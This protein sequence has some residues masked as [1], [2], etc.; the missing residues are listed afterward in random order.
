MRGR[1][2]RRGR[3]DRRRGRR[4]ARPGLRVLRR[5]SRAGARAG[6]RLHQSTAVDARRAQTPRVAPA[7]RALFVRADSEGMGATRQSG[8]SP[9]PMRAGRRSTISYSARCSSAGAAPRSRRPSASADASWKSASAPA[10]RCRIIRAPTDSSASTFPSRCCARRR[11]GCASCKLDNVETLAGDGRQP[12]RL[13]RRIPSTWW[14]RNMS[15]P[16]CPIRRQ[17][18][19]NSRACCKPGGEIVLVNHISAESGHAPQGFE[20][21]FAPVARRLGW[22]PE[23]PWARLQ[24]WIDGRKRHARD[25]AQADAAARAFFADAVRQDGLS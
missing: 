21:G 12:S 25:R 22:R 9:R 5:G 7:R 14:W 10:S 18:S 2:G 19:T 23:F 20:L 16:P 8:R 4:F 1:R 11:S 24:H 13:S 3:A 15:S 17:R 6:R